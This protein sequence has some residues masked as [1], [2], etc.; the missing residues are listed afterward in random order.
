VI[1]HIQ[2]VRNIGQ[3][4][5]VNAGA[6][7]LTKLVVSYAENSRGKTTMAA[8]FRSLSTGAADTD[9]AGHLF[10]PEAGRRSETKPDSVPI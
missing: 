9:E 6:I 7:R 1:E 2:L 8:I 4:D 10:Q 3:F 5:S